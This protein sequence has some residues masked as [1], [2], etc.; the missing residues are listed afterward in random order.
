MSRQLD[1]LMVSSWDFQEH[2]M[3]AILRTPLHF[4][5]RGH[6]V[7]FLVHSELTSKPSGV[8][9][10]HPNIRVR[11]FD[12]PCKFLRS[13]PKLN[14]LRQLSLF[15]ICSLRSLRRLYAEGRRPDVVYAAECDAILLGTLLR[16]RYRVP[17]VCRYYGISTVLM[18]HP[19][20]HLLYRLALT[21]QCDMAVVTDDGTD[22][23]A[24]LGKMNPRIGILKFW[25][26]GIDPPHVDA[27]RVAA[28]RR[29]H[30]VTD[31]DFVMMTNS[32]LYGWKRVDRAIRVLSYLTQSTERT[33]KLLVVGHGPERARLEC[34]AGELG[35]SDV[36]IFAG[37]VHHSRIYDY[38][39]VADVLLSLYDM[40]NL[41]NPTWEALNLGRCV[42]ALQCG[43][44]DSVITHGQN[45]LLVNKSEDEETLVEDVAEAVK[46][47]ADDPDLH[48]RLELGARRLGEEILWT[49]NE[50]LDAEAEAIEAL[51][52]ESSAS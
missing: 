15:T 31:N 16:R 28:I 42:V 43:Y 5:E 35:V 38:Y 50:R 32:R 7:T 22:G 34:L 39:A 48:Q 41:G 17:F 2:G 13:I 30:Q 44:E 47:L 1:I 37:A 40:S 14:R 27:D 33:V 9:D 4:A 19:I 46:T 12:L 25:R 6:R 26:N 23:A 18:E 29:R 45:G 52:R 11:R 20:R 36:V 10:L 24:V 51:V 21:R 49:W 3:Q 8:Q